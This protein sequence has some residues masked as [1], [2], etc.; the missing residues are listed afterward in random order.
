MFTTEGLDHVAIIVKDVK[1]SVAWYREVLGLERLHDA[2]GDEPAFVGAGGTGLAIFQ[3]TGDDDSRIPTSHSRIG[4]NHLAFR[5][6]GPNFTASQSHL[7]S[8]GVDFHFED[9]QIA[10]SI[11]FTDPDGHRLEITTY[12]LGQVDSNLA[13]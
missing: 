8:L 1:R 7:D 11:Y 3:V 5:V 9:H 12:D 6:D 4:L 10:H 2:W 13:S